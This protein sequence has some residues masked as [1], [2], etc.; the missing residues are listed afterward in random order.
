MNKMASR[1][2]IRTYT[3]Y[4]D[5]HPDKKIAIITIEESLL[6]SF[7]NIKILDK[8]LVPLDI[9]LVEKYNNTLSGAISC[10]EDR[11][12]PPNRCFFEDYCKKHNLDPYNINDRLKLN[13]GRTYYDDIYVIMEE[14]ITD[15]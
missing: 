13:Q 11:A 12:M 1:K 4:S 15:V 3:F 6:D 2:I 8:E 10:L 14:T 9:I 7:G 5:K